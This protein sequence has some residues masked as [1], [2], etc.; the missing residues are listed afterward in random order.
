MDQTDL[1]HDPALLRDA[2]VRE[3]EVEARDT[4]RE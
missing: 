2:G 3:R 1:V 4:P